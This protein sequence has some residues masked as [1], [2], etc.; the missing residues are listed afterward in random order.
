MVPVCHSEFVLEYTQNQSGL[1]EMSGL[2]RKMARIRAFELK[3]QS[4]KDVG[5]IPGSIHLAVG[6]EAI[7]VGF[8]DELKADDIVGATYRGHG[9]A[10]AKGIPP[11]DIFAEMMG[12]DSRLNGGRGASLYFSSAKHHFLGE[13]S[14]VGAGAPIAAGAALSA[15]NEGAGRVVIST[16]GDGAANQGVVLETFN[17]S[18]VMGLPIIF[19]VENNVYSEMS[20]IVD[21]MRGKSLASRA[22]GF[23]IHSYAIDGNDPLQVIGAARDSI[24]RAR[25]GDGPTFVEAHTVRLAGHYSGD[26]QQ[27]RSSEEIKA[28]WEDEPLA[29]L[30]KAADHST[31]SGYDA[32][33][34]EVQSEVAEAAEEARNLPTPD[35]ATAGRYLYVS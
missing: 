17:M 22:A 13:N 19:V 20:P 4:L 18:A 23:G 11:V 24:D 35:P 12:R 28:A 25:R 9:W 7:P 8:C 16:F 27:Y 32:I 26:A 30:R 14:I 34:D 2:Y 31:L 3:T 33:D 21:M 15:R 6:Q 10:L 1:G 5:E 29:R